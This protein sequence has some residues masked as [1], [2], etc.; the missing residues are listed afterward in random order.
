MQ[1]GGERRRCCVG[2]FG[3]GL[4]LSREWVLLREGESMTS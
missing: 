2:M 3:E 1:D 4:R